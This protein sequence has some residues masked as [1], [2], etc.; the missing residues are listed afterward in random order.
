MATSNSFDFERQIEF[1]F[2]RATEIAA[3]NTL[4]WFGKGQKEK[5]RR[6]SLRCH[7]WNV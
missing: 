2:L 6:S 7:P 1:D 5:S 4:Q 3:L